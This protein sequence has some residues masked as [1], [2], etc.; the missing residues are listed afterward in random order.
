MSIYRLFIAIAVFFALLRPGTAV[1]AATSSLTEQTQPIQQLKHRSQQLAQ[2]GRRR[3][4]GYRNNYNRNLQNQQRLNRQRLQRQNLRRQREIQRQN[5]ARRQ[6]E[7]RA[8]QERMR[9]QMAE[10]RRLQQRRMQQARLRQQRL[11]RRRQDMA[12][13][14]QKKLQQ[15]RNRDFTHKQNKEKRGRNAAIAAKAA[16]AATGVFSPRLNRRLNR[17]SSR[18]LRGAANDNRPPKAGSGS[19]S[20]G[21]GKGR[22]PRNAG[23]PKGSPDGG[24]GPNGPPGGGG[25]N[26]NDG[27]AGPSGNEPQGPKIALTPKFNA[28]A[29]LRLKQIYEAH[30]RKKLTPTLKKDFG[31]AAKKGVATGKFQEAAKNAS[32]PVTRTT[33]EPPTK[34]L[35]PAKEQGASSLAGSVIKP[36]SGPLKPHWDDAVH[37]KKPVP[38]GDDGNGD[39]AD[40][41][42]DRRHEPRVPLKYP[43]PGF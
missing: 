27:K 26:K 5:M 37:P 18:V 30:A 34:S 28:A 15:K 1:E 16:L 19:G 22:P 21:N 17:L 13:L 14:R 8:K 11:Q 9:R 12:R 42:P 38:D 4:F 31:I 3:G 25:G 10:R 36:K 33:I 32:E 6:R 43:N 40:P 23:G 41:P 35:K 39:K 2:F 20:G 29:R 24:G 7:M